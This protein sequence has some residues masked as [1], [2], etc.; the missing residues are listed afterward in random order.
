[1]KKMLAT[2]VAAALALSL[3]ALAGCGQSDQGDQPDPAPQPDPVEQGPT[4]E[5][6]EAMV[7]DS[8][9]T[10]LEAVKNLDDVFVSALAADPSIAELEVYGIDAERYADRYFKGFD[11]AVG[12][13]V[14]SDDRTSATIE[15]ALTV[16]SAAEY[17]AILER[18]FQSSMDAWAAE[19]MSE[20]EYNKL[21]GDTMMG[22]LGMVD[23]APIDPIA[24]TYVEQ[25]GAWMPDAASTAALSAAIMGS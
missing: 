8:L 1:M 15:V 3:L 23:A 17:A 12:D 5:E 10:E 22:L 7:L 20:E 16:K 14:V 24:L 4:A 2:V 18:D 6:V 9:T 21:V 11:Y 25:D 13:V 19:S